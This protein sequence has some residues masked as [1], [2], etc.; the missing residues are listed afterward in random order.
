[1]QVI[2]LQ[3]QVTCALILIQPLHAASHKP[4]DVQP[5]HAPS[6]KPTD[7]QPLHAASHRPTDV[8]PPLPPLSGLVGVHS[9]G[10]ISQRVLG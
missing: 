8:L 7:V 1:M 4:T 2:C 3:Y 10:S 6:H 5:L 9:E